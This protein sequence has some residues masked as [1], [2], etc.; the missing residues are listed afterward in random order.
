MDS[1]SP[2][3]GPCALFFLLAAP[4]LAIAVAL[5]GLDPFGRLIAAL[6]GAVA[7]DMLVAQAMLTVHRWSVTGGIVAVTVLSLLIL[8]ATRVRQRAGSRGRTREGTPEGSKTGQSFVTA[9]P[10]DS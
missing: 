7:L 6:A 5:G 3:R 8:L 1:G 4:A 9:K 10:T 2:L